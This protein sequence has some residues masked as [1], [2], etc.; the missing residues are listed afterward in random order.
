MKILSLLE[1]SEVPKVSGF[2]V[3]VAAPDVSELLFVL[4]FVSS[5]GLA[6]SGMYISYSD[7]VML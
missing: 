5:T 2:H 4:D 6:S 7:S 3:I 1:V